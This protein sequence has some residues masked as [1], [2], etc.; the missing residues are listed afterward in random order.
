MGRDRL[1]TL[2][3]IETAYPKILGL[4]SIRRDRLKTLIGIETENQL[5]H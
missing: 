4:D 5:D 1:K 2:I 3:G